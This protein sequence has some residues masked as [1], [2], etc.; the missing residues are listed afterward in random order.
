MYLG[1]ADILLIWNFKNNKFCIFSSFPSI[2]SPFPQQLK[3]SIAHIL[4]QE[5][6]RKNLEA[7]KGC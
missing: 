2:L 6:S 4:Y 3:D 1:L 5:K 7:K